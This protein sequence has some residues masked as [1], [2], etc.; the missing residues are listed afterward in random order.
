MG[1]TDNYSIFWNTQYAKDIQQF[2]NSNSIIGNNKKNVYALYGNTARKSF[3]IF[4]SIVFTLDMTLKVF[5]RHGNC[6]DAT[7]RE[8][9]S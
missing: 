2:R 9:I 8:D 6:L 1:A 4:S 7:S 5:S 3:N